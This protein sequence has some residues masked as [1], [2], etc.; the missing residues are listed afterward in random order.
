[1]NKQLRY[2]EKEGYTFISESGLVYD[3]YE[4][5]CLGGK[6]TSDIIIIMLSVDFDAFEMDYMR[7][8]LLVGFVYGASEFYTDHKI[9]ENEVEDITYII[10][11]KVEEYEKNHSEMIND[12]RKTMFSKLLNTLEKYRNY[13]DY[14]PDTDE[15]IDLQEQTTFL[16]NMIDIRR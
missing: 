6:A 4:A 14:N 10:R 11:G 15:Y 9:N 3:L 2:D 12:Y 8:D 1:M 13:I 16:R 5:V 7:H